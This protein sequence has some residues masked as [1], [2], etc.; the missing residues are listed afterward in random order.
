MCLTGWPVVLPATPRGPTGMPEATLPPPIT[1]RLSGW[2]CDCMA[3]AKQGRSAGRAGGAQNWTAFNC[4]FATPVY[5]GAHTRRVGARS[6]WTVSITYCDGSPGPIRRCRG[7]TRGT[8]AGCTP[9]RCVLSVRSRVASAQV[10]RPAQ[11][12]SPRLIRGFRAHALDAVTPLACVPLPADRLRGPPAVSCPAQA[13]GPSD[14]R[15]TGELARST[16]LPHSPGPAPDQ[17]EPFREPTWAD[18][19][20][21]SAMPSPCLGCSS[22]QPALLGDTQQYQ[23]CDWGSRGRRFKSGRPDAGQSLVPGFSY[24]LLAAMGAHVRSHP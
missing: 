2:R 8:S 10:E 23:G 5:R 24:R 12:S 13:E 14:R 17:G 15:A 19:G 7:T 21:Q 22:A 20:R 4:G 9:V 11:P 6:P 18:F 1:A 16:A 3:E